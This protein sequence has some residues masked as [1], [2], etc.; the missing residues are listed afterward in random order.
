METLL[1]EAAIDGEAGEAERLLRE[2]N[3]DPNARNE[4]CVCQVA[5]I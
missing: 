3:A 5:L 2:E 4:V 1:H